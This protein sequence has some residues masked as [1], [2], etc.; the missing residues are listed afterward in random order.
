MDVL[1]WTTTLA[2]LILSIALILAITR[3]V[4]GPTIPNR[5]LAVDLIASI[6]ICLMAVSAVSSSEETMLEIIIV[7]AL[8]SFIATVALVN[9]L[10]KRVNSK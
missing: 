5:A 6:V 2:S 8:L 7:W 3:V 1:F 4:L 9:F 10:E